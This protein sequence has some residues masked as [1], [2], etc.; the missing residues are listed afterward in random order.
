MKSYLFKKFLYLVAILVIPLTAISQ[1]PTAVIT[2]VASGIG[3]VLVNPIA[4]Q[5]QLVGCGQT[6]P[7]LIPSGSVVTNNYTVTADP[8]T[9]IATAT[10]YGSDIIQCGNQALTTYAVTW[11]IQGRPAAPT[12]IYRVVQ[13]QTCSV[14]DGTCKPIGF[15][16]AQ[17]QNATASICAGNTVLSGFNSNFVPVCSSITGSPLTFGSITA[18]LGFTPM[19]VGAAAGGDLAGTYPN[20][21]VPN[22][23]KVGT[24]AGGD[25]GGTYPNPTV[26][27][28]VKTAPAGN[29]NVTQ[30]TGTSLQVSN[31]NGVLNANLFSG[32]DLGAKVT[33]AIAELGTTCGTVYI[34]NGTY[35]W[36]TH[37]VL[38]NPC[39]RIEGDGAVINVSTGTDPFLV[40]AA[41][42]NFSLVT[43]YTHGGISGNINFVGPGAG[44][45]T[46]SSAGIWIGGDPAGVITPSSY[47]AFQMTF[48]N[49]HLQKFG[50]GVT[51]GTVFQIAFLGGTFD[52]N[53]AGV[54]GVAAGEDIN[55]HGTQIINNIQYGI[56]APNAGQEYSLYGVS[57]DYNGQTLPTTGAQIYINAPY[58]MN[59]FGGH[60]EN[61]YTPFIV[62][63]AGSGSGTINI[64]NTRITM[65]NSI[66]GTPESYIV[67]GGTNSVLNVNNLSIN[68]VSSV[69]YLPASLVN[70]NAAGG[71]NYLS[72]KGLFHTFQNNGLLLPVFKAGNTP[73]FYDI[74]TFDSSGDN[75]GNNINSITVG[76]SMKN[77]AGYQTFR[78][79]G[80]VTA[81]AAVP[82]VTAV[83]TWP[84]P[85]ANTNY[86]MVCLLDTPSPAVAPAA[87]PFIA[88]VATK[89]ATSFSL[90]IANTTATAA[91]GNI[92][93]IASH[94]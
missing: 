30:T 2:G 14:S 65:S 21:T 38:M 49:F 26:T 54:C 34:P 51:L 70:Y 27:G 33:A 48:T 24:A 80:G 6:V 52:G 62:V 73:N 83:F 93:C 4:L 81:T 94:D 64:S 16:P 37:K 63:P 7:Q 47:Q 57:L 56:Y 10:V 84:V 60:F 43:I 8:V 77:G 50:C 82:A 67:M 25:L 3:Q 78:G 31:F 72:V 61:H 90:T 85:M 55:F 5:I 32:G 74:N 44:V 28:A 39:Q 1:T 66:A 42:P 40:F 88:N 79:A 91:G 58:S 71:N 23:I 69:A 17:I 15:T 41:L 35:T 13:G 45:G 92:N 20:P 18:G 36:T 75:T 53:Y 87:A 9:H 19:A 46:S 12:A 89:T 22:A 86:T 29:Q 76:A 59:I 68:N 11:L